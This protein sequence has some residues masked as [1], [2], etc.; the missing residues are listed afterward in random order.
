MA[1][2][3]DHILMTMSAKPATALQVIATGVYEHVLEDLVGP[4]AQATGQAVAFVITNAGGV[5]AKL[6]ADA[7]ADVVMTSGVGIDSLAAKGKVVRASKVDVGGMRLG[8]AITAGLPVPDI[9]TADALRAALRAAPAVA[10]IDPHGGGTS[11]PFIAKVFE[12]L[13][14]ADE[15]R[16]RGILCATGGDV[17][18]AVA[19]GEAALG[20]TQAAE[21]IGLPGIAFAGFLPAELQLVTVYSA[22]VTSQAKLPAAAAAFISFITGP[23]AAARLRSSGWDAAPSAG[24]M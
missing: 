9:A 14:V 2:Q 22:A 15:V 8:V 17:V 24:Q 4:F 3:G 1:N 11:G 13:G 7:A 20:M 12:R 16:A 23:A 5:I 10:S 18:R 19:S 6:D 21:L